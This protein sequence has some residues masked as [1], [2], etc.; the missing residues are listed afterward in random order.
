IVVDLVDSATADSSPA[1]SFTVSSTSF[2]SPGAFL[3]PQVSMKQVQ[4]QY[5]F[6]L[7]SERSSL[8]HS[9]VLRFQTS[10]EGPNF[11]E[12]R[13]ASDTSLP[14]GLWAFHE[15]LSK[16]VHTT[17]QFGL[18]KF[19]MQYAWPQIPNT[20]HANKPP[21]QSWE[22]LNGQTERLQH[23][24]W[25]SNICCHHPHL[26][27]KPS[28]HPPPTAAIQ[29]HSGCPAHR[30]TSLSTSGYRK[31]HHNPSSLLH[32]PQSLLCPRQDPPS[33]SSCLPATYMCST[34][35]CSSSNMVDSTALLLEAHLQ[36]KPSS[37]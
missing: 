21:T 11:Q 16:N 5:P 12:G 32:T 23:H 34:S 20:E 29:N 36:I 35:S 24:Q 9:S 28:P 3:D 15:H 2:I 8:T 33:H 7:K 4:G 14:Q 31:F 18:N 10:L 19:S 17:G 6:S 25:T 27:Q 22:H 26:L 30:L 1:S 13:R 37:R